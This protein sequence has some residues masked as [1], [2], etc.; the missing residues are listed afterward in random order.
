[1][2]NKLIV[3]LI[4]TLLIQTPIYFYLVIQILKRVQATELM[5]FL[6]WVYVPLSMTVSILVKYLCSK[7]KK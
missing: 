1:M 4:T 3:V 2:K 6:F 5:W 7:E